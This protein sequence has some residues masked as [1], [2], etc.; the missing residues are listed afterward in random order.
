MKGGRVRD[1]WVRAGWCRND[2]LD[3]KRLEM[4]GEVGKHGK[5]RTGKKRR[6]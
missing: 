4:N 5:R 1:G 6:V 3:K 2:S